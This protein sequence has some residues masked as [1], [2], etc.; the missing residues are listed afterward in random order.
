MENDKFEPVD[1]GREID[2]LEIGLK[3][4]SARKRILIWSLIGAVFGILVALSIPKEYEVTV[5]L[6]PEAGESKMGNNLGALAA[7]AGINMGNTGS[8][9]AVSPTLYPDI[10]SSIPFTVELFNVVLPTDIENIDSIKLQDFILDHTSKPWWSVLSGIP[11]QLAGGV[12]SLFSGRNNE[13][14]E[15]DE[16]LNPFRL[17]P[18][19]QGIAATINQRVEADVDNKT[20]VV[21]ITVTLQDPVAAASL[22]DIVTKRLQEYIIDYRTGKARNDLEYTKRINDEARDAYYRTQQEYARYADRNQGL[23]SKSASVEQERLQNETELAFNLYNSTAQQVQ[24]AEAKVQSN[25]PVFAVIEPA[26]VPGKPTKPR[27]MIILIGF[28]FLAAVLASAYTLFAPSFIGT[29]KEKRN[30]LRNK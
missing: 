7:F 30:A 21:S 19:Q 27:K 11:M 10:V 17:N 2:L 15:N 28:V 22:A 9:D 20:N 24:M 1:D 14:G 16:I 3:L 25:T 12:K 29:I 6:V 26:T 13:E 23:V 8:T 4:W 18:K 5:K